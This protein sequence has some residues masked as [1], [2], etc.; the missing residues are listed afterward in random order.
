MTG[1]IKYFLIISFLFS[2]SLLSA[3]QRLTLPEALDLGTRNYGSI[4]SKSFQ[5]QSSEYALSQ[6]R[7]DYLPNLVISGQQVYGTINGQNGPAYGFGGYGVSS[8][9]LPLSEQN[10]NAAFGALYLANVNWEVFTF[11]RARGRIEVANAGLHTAE[12]DLAQEQFKHQ[13]RVAAA[14]LNALAAQRLATAQQKNLERAL[15]IQRAVSARAKTGLVAGVDSSLANAEVANSRIALAR[16]LDL[17][18]EEEKKVALLVGLDEDHLELDTAFVSTIPHQLTGSTPSN[19]HPSLR[20]QQSRVD[21]SLMQ[22]K[23][24]R[25]SYFPSLNIVGVFQ[26]RASGFEASYVQDQEAFSH[27][28]SDGIKPTR[29]NYLVGVGLTWNLTSIARANAQVKS[30]SFANMAAQADLELSKQQ[31]TTQ[32]RIA[33]AKLSNAVLISSEAPVQ[34]KYA[35]DAY[36]QKSALYKNGLATIVDLTQTLYVLNR[37]EADRDIAFINVWQALLLNASAAGDL[38]LFTNELNR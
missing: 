23:L 28:Y 29:A 19:L 20:Y 17:Q 26:G 5:V 3:Q 37:A 11:G 9:G 25:A 33:A 4:K 2:V 18:Q 35:N 31:L 7:R 36:V 22:L 6:S 21:Q 12:A 8:S 15:V 13:I 30:L 10:W 38:T 1:R 34:V 27:S 24:G 16:A 14:Y 32:S